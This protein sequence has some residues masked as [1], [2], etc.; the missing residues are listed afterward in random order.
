MPRLFNSLCVGAAALH[1]AIIGCGGG[2]SIE[3][4]NIVGPD[5]IVS[6]PLARRWQVDGCADG[7]G[8]PAL[9]PHTPEISVLWEQRK[10]MLL[11][12]RPGHARLLVTNWFRADKSLVFQAI[13][14]GDNPW[15]YE[16]RVPDSPDAVGRLTVAREWEKSSLQ[17]GG[18]RAQYRSVVLTC[19]LEKKLEGN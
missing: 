5:Q 18:F 7:K 6:S 4:G 16:F 14:R 1:S 3:G 15:L 19:R 9:R 11:E 12:A 10:P 8:A 17:H 2:P 13:V